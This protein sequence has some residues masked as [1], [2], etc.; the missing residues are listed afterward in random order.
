MGVQLLLI[1]NV[2]RMQVDVARH[3]DEETWHDQLNDKDKE[4]RLACK[5]SAA[6]KAVE[7][8]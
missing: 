2:A 7:K 1:E 4:F 6:N 3:D 8:N 5:K